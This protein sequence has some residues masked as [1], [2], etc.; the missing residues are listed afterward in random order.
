MRRSETRRAGSLRWVVAFFVVTYAVTGLLW[1]P[2]LRSGQSPSKLSNRL[3]L[4]LLLATIAPSAV[5]IILSAVENGRSG[6]RELLGQFGRWRFGPGWYAYAILIAPI[7]AVVILL[8]TRAM[9]GHAPAPAAPLQFL[10]PLAPLGEE[11]GWRGYALPRLQSRMSAVSA[12][13]LIGVIWACWHLPYF[14][15]ADVHPLVFWIGFPLFAAVIIAESLLATWLYNST[16]GSVLATFIFHWSIT[17]GSVV[18]VVP[19]VAAAVVGAL[20]NLLAGAGAVA[21]GGRSLQGI[22]LGRGQ[23]QALGT[24][25]R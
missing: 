4:F 15:F 16:R 3:E 1:L 20:V 2:I 10:V 17:A 12:G 9:G 25:L 5:A 13:L 21:L 19:G 18:P 7:I 24:D 14:A 8:I 22:S 6:L 23:Q 11:L